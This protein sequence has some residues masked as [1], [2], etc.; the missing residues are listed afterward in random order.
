[1]DNIKKRLA[2]IERELAELKEAQ[3]ADEETLKEIQLIMEELV[4]KD[5]VS[6]GQERQYIEKINGLLKKRRGKK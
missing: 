5:T 2:E 4:K 6:H 1:M 3:L